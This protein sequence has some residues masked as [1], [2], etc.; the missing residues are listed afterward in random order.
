MNG[1]EYFGHG[2]DGHWFDRRLRNW[3]ADSRY[4]LA[5]CLDLDAGLDEVLIASRHGNLVADVAT[6][7]DIDEGLAAILPLTRSGENVLDLAGHT[8]PFYTFLGAYAAGFALR[9][10]TERLL[11]RVWLPLLWLPAV[12]HLTAFTD[13]VYGFAREVDSGEDLDRSEV[14]DFA[15]DIDRSYDLEVDMS[16]RRDSLVNSVYGLLSNPA[17]IYGIVEEFTVTLRWSLGQALYYS[18]DMEPSF[19]VALS[20]DLAYDPLYARA[21]DLGRAVALLEEAATS[22][23]GADFTDLDLQ[24][25]P[26][27]GVRWTEATRWPATWADRIRCN[28]VL[29]GPGLWEIRNGRTGTG[30]LAEGTV[31]R[32]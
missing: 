29:I 24:G 1:D 4:D 7:L 6:A 25:I 3:H 16:L 22:M 28:S 21:H 9:R 14:G 12:R 19:V 26:L 5:S 13:R 15:R 2:F 17:R 23:S 27:E 10:P 11:A 31:C 30:V 32:T 20:R 8:S 18:R